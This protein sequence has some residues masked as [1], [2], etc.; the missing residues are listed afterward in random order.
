M[1]RDLKYW[2]LEGRFCKSR[3]GPSDGHKQ[4]DLSKLLA[5]TEEELDALYCEL[6]D[7]VGEPWIRDRLVT[8][9][10]DPDGAG[11]ES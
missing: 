5:K 11:G 6:L 10:A 3:A 2:C 1:I 9:S 4:L 7:D 8:G